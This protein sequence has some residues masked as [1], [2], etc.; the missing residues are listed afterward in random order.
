MGKGGVREMDLRAGLSQQQTLKLTMTQEL[1]QAIQLLQYSAVELI[2]FLE[3]K[4]LENPLLKVEN[5]NGELYRRKKNG[6][7]PKTDE[8]AWIEQIGDQR[9]TLA[10]HVFPQVQVMKISPMQ[11]K[12]VAHCI[13]HLDSNGYFTGDLQEI[14]DLYGISLSE[15]EECLAILQRVD[16]PGIGARN[17]QECLLLQ[18]RRKKDKNELAE[19]IISGHFKMFA[20]KKWKTLAK[21]LGVNIKEIQL[22]SDYIQ[23]LN[24]KPGAAFQYERAPYIIPDVAV[25]REGEQFIVQPFDHFLP[26]IQF[27]KDY[28]SNLS[29][30]QDKKVAKF[31]YDKQQDYLWIIRSLEQRQTTI[32]NVTRKIVEKQYDYFK[33]GPNFLKP[34]TMKEISEELGIHESTVSRA[35]REKYVQTPFGTVELKSFFTNAIESTS[36]EFLSSSKVKAALAKIVK[37]E[38]KRKPYSD[39]EIV[40]LLKEREGIVVSRRTVAKYRDQLGIA[41]SAKRKRFD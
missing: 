14:A 2:D 5:H 10:D 32:L 4:A 19:R 39:S 34:M 22:V 21:E 9:F 25:V 16:P 1:S 33:K 40:Q 27:N 20:E 35:V 17:L 41:S 30:Y 13:Y 6:H 31:L 8:K 36:D 23:T 29:S 26:N 7:G 15:A 12:I 3:N 38:N 37:S 24:P 28:F 18:I 11:Q